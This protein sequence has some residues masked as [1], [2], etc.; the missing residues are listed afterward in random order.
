VGQYALAVSS[1]AS[2]AAHA[3]E[4]VTGLANVAGLA[5]VDARL[6]APPPAKPLVGI[7]AEAVCAGAFDELCTHFACKSGTAR[8]TTEAVK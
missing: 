7:P 3:L 6:A 2:T 5:V 1:S 8:H 4:P